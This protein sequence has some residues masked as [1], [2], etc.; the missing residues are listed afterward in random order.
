MKK[1]LAISLC[2]ML[3]GMF[4]SSCKKSGASNMDYSGSYKGNINLYINGTLF[5]TLNSHT[6]VLTSTS[7]SGQVT[8]N[9]NVIQSTSASISG[10]TLTIP[11]TVVSSITNFKTIEYGNGTFSGNTLA[12]EFTKLNFSF[13][14]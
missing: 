4:L 11:N 13:I 3:F 5:T 10:D 6:I 12:I 9:N 8:L 7:T 14:I 2:I 1:V